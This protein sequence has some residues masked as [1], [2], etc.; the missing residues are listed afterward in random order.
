[1]LK[2]ISNILVCFNLQK[3]ISSIRTYVLYKK[4]DEAIRK[5]YSDRTRPE[6]KRFL[7]P[8]L[9]GC[10]AMNLQGI[11]MDETK[12]FIF[13]DLIEKDLCV[14]EMHV[15]TK[16]MCPEWLKNYEL[17]KKSIDCTLQD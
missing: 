5:W 3:H 10:G 7:I 8:T 4:Y 2:T 1:M 12:D 11:T 13:E 9:F 16:Y 17:N 14:Y 15:S 6:G